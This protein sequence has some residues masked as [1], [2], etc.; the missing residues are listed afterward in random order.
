MR[1]NLV[2]MA[3][4]AAAA[5]AGVT[6]CGTETSGG[7][8]AQPAGASTSASASSVT[9]GPSISPVPTPT[10]TAASKDVTIEKQQLPLEVYSLKRDG[11]FVTLQFGLKNSTKDLNLTSGSWLRGSPFSRTGENDVS[12][13]YL[14]DGKN[15]KKYEPAVFGQ[16]CMCSANLDERQAGPGQTIYLNATYAAPPEDVTTMDVNFPNFGTLT[17]IPVS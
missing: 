7:N 6:A 8:A 12:G 17:K 9:D 4:L 5:L 13:V 1:R 14:V 2:V 15:K 3:S 10:Q 11:T 16:N